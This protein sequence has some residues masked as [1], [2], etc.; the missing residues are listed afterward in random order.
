MENKKLNIAQVLPSLQSGGVER[1]TLEIAN[2]LVKK[3]HR[4]YVISSGGR[5]VEELEKK[6]SNHL[7]IPIDKKSIFTF[8][9]IPKIIKFIHKNKI[10]I[11][12]V[13]SRFPA[14]IIYL[15]LFF[16]SKDK[17]PFF[18]TTV[19]GFNSI[20]LYSKI[21]TKGDKVIVVSNFI[22]NFII[23]T[24][25]VDKK[26]ICLIHRGE[27]NNLGPKNA[28]N[29]SLWKKSFE[30]EYK[31]LKNKKVLTIAAR[32][33]RTKGIEIFIDLI[34]SILDEDNNIHGLIVGEAKSNNYLNKLHKKIKR[35][36]LEK[37]ITIT[38]Y[39]SDIYNILQYSYITYCLSEVP[40]PFGRSVVESIKLGTPVIAFNHGGAGE[41]LKET[42]PEG[43]INFRDFNGLQNKTKSFLKRRPRVLK[44]NKFS[45]EKMREQTLN[46][47]LDLLRQH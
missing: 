13:R 3:G 31:N 21:M 9:V 5:L 35:L 37:N 17:R 6:G 2:Y 27:P 39:R 15:A 47:Y 34:N 42:F 44:T 18:V 33:S 10:D 16:I 14:W 32:L 19:H 43:M 46:V 41:Q 38:G 36:N 7:N 24:Y 20:S 4:S 11:V 40:E 29:F 45:L 30:N 22:K 28:R 26:K 25:G 1:G 8:L 23:D 12:H